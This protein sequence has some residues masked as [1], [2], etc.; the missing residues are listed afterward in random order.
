MKPTNYLKLTVR[1]GQP[2]HD[3]EAVRQAPSADHWPLLPHGYGFN[4]LGNVRLFVTTWLF[5]FDGS[6]RA[7]TMRALEAAQDKRK[8]LRTK[9]FTLPLE[10]FQ[11]SSWKPSGIKGVPVVGEPV[12]TLERDPTELEVVS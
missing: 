7:D 6:S 5:P 2:M 1:T 4:G 8:R 12:R 9:H 11:L 3:S 10:A